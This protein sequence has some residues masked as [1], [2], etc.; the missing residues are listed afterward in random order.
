MTILVTGPRGNVGFVVAETLQRS[1]EP[2]RL[3]SRSAAS[4]CAESVA[5]D[6]TD[7]RR[8]PGL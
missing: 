3:A 5:F 1:G 7:Q 2:V 8:G 4:A 6:F